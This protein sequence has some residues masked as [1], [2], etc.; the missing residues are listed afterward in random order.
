VQARG[1]SGTNL[2]TLRLQNI[3]FQTTNDSQTMTFIHA[4]VV[5]PLVIGVAGIFGMDFLQKVGAEISLPTGLLTIND[6]HFRLKNSRS[7]TS[8]SHIVTKH[9]D[10]AR[11]L[12]NRES[13]GEPTGS[14]SSG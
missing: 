8:V 1:I 6:C 2:E 14:L 9:T 7:Q 10:P 11:G 12:A 3:K 5:C 13:G 4:F